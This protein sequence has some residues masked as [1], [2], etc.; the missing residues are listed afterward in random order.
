MGPCYGS[1]R[2]RKENSREGASSRENSNARQRETAERF[3][4][5]WVIWKGRTLGRTRYDHS[6]RST[7]LTSHT[8]GPGVL[9][10]HGARTSGWRKVFRGRAWKGPRQEDP[11]GGRCLNTKHRPH[12]Y[13]VNLRIVFFRTFLVV[14]GLRIH[15]QYRGRRVPS[16]IRELKIPRA[17]G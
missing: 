3:S 9:S 6:T 1:I 12:H 7:S 13:E 16:L 2:Y 8:A 14:Q 10:S 4:L 5:Q 15:L 17:S 11:Q